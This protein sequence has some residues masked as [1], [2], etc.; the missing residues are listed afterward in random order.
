MLF[1]KKFFEFI[2]NVTGINNP[3]KG[4]NVSH[5]RVNGQSA[6]LFAANNFECLKERAHHHFSS[7]FKLYVYIIF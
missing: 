2:I 5:A 4:R 7:K 6:F 1:K 3:V